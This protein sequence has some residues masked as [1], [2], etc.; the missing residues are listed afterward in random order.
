MLDPQRIEDLITPRTR[1]V[2]MTAASNVC[3]T[4]MPLREASEICR[5]RQVRFIVDSAQVAGLFP[6]SMDELHI[7][8]LT[9]TG[10]KGLL[11]P[12]GIGGM[13]LRPELAEEID[14]LVSGGTGTWGYKFRTQGRTEIVCVEITTEKEM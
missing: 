8:A 2:V 4:L 6:L 12:Q 9:F 7:D 10:H 1:A 11:G 3:G 14:P 5:R 13:I